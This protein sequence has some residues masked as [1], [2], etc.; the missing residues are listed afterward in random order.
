MSEQVN[1]FLKDFINNPQNY[2][3]LTTSKGELFYQKMDYQKFF[4]EEE[5]N[6]YENDIYFL[7][8]CFYEDKIKLYEEKDYDYEEKRIEEIQKTFDKSVRKQAEEEFIRITEIGKQIKRNNELIRELQEKGKELEKRRL[9]EAKTVF[10]I[11]TKKRM[12]E[13]LD[14]FRAREEAHKKANFCKSCKKQFKKLSLHLAKS[15]KCN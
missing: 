12:Q 3:D 2:L 7:V 9:L 5:L 13:E 11:E 1:Y 10:D 6:E 14:R 15:S 4:G 8:D